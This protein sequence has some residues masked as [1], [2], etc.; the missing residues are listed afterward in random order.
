MPD[1]AFFENGTS[2]YYVKSPYLF[3]NIL[4]KKQLIKKAADL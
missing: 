2:A 4:E 3:L 1:K